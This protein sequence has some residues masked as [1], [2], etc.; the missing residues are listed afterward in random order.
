MLRTTVLCLSLLVASTASADLISDAQKATVNILKQ[1][2]DGGMSHV[3]TGTIYEEVEEGYDGA[4][5]DGYYIATASHCVTGSNPDGRQTLR[6]ETYFVSFDSVGLP[7][8][9][10]PAHV[11]GAGATARGDDFA[12]FHAYTDE[13]WRVAKMGVMADL[14]PGDELINIAAPAG[15]GLQVF[16]GNVSL[17]SLDRPIKGGPINWQ[18]AM[19]AQIPGAG[20]SSGSAVWSVEQKAIV[21]FVVGLIGGNPSTVVV[22]VSRFKA[23]VRTYSGRVAGGE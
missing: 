4:E 6:G 3:C 9:F 7:K 17:L 22:P 11:E 18:F 20:G 16:R 13:K 21:G 19:L 5:Q 12:V 23:W 14:K 10:Y 15:L 2:R 1:T 8:V